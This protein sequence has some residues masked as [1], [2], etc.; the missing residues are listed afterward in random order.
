MAVRRALASDEY[1]LVLGLSEIVM[2]R[3]RKS[4]AG[5]T[6]SSS[7]RDL[8]RSYGLRDLTALLARPEF[9]TVRAGPVLG[10]H[11]ADPVLRLES[12]A[13]ERGWAPGASLL[14]Y[15]IVDF[16]PKPGTRPQGPRG[17]RPVL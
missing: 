3:V 8:S 1:R 9:R 5:W 10:Q 11:D 17:R 4:R 6:A 2:R 16:F 12:T 15:W 7:L 13:L 14:S